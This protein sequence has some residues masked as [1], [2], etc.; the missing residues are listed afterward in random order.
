MYTIDGH[1]MTI[2]RDHMFSDTWVLLDAGE[3][4]GCR[5]L[6]GSHEGGHFV[7]Q[8]HVADWRESGTGPASGWNGIGSVKFQSHY[9]FYT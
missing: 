1:H 3:G 7:L 9:T 6:S 5:D 2:A 4:L 8:E